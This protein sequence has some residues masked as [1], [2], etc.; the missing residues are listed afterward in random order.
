MTSRK[1]TTF[2]W[3][4]SLDKTTSFTIVCLEQRKRSWTKAGLRLQEVVLSEA[5]SSF[6]AFPT[7]RRATAALKSEKRPKSQSSSDDMGVD[8]D[9]DSKLYHLIGVRDVR[10]IVWSWASGRAFPKRRQNNSS[11]IRCG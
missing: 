5:R 3:L 2:W 9:V 7:S 1:L 11:L 6:S 4:A 10:V 8:G